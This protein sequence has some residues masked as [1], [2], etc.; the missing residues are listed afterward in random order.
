MNILLTSAGRRVSL[1]KAFLEAAHP[2]GSKVFVADMDPLAPACA[3][4][5]GAFQVPRVTALDYIP[6]LLGLC[7]R[8]QIQLIVPTI[9][10]E[11]Q[12]LADH[13]SRFLGEG[14][15]S[16]ISSP[17]FVRITGDKWLTFQAFKDAGIPVPASW[18]PETADDRLPMDLFL[19]PRDGSASSHIYPCQRPDLDRMLPLVPHPIIQERLVGQ[20][21]T[22]DACFDL[23]GRPLHFVPRE[24]IRTLGGESIQ[25]VT[26]DRPDVDAW[27][28]TVLEACSRLGARGPLT[29]QA[30]LTPDG[31]VLSEINPRFGGGFPLARA[32]GGD[33]PAWI[34]RMLRGEALAPTFGAYRKNLYMTRHHTEVFLEQ[35]PW[36]R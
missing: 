13:A 16:L 20:E 18:L 27:L 17:D 6:T 12:I 2:M 23:Q 25:G 33:Y 5:D 28:V 11:L 30:F 22:I 34:L 4:A 36:A 7:Q 31:P 10:T 3:L 32:A 15:T 24:R 14:I 26:L 21:I 29:L 8:Q 1:L 19:K 35:L 9:D